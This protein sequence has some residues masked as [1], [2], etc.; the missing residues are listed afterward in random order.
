LELYFSEL[1]IRL[2]AK[3]N[4]LMS[5]DGDR[6]RRNTWVPIKEL[7]DFPELKQWSVDVEQAIEAIR[8]SAHLILSED[9][10]SV[11]RS[12]R[13]PPIEFISHTIFVYNF[14]ESIPS[15]EWFESAFSRF[16]RVYA[17]NLCKYRE[18]GLPKSKL[19]LDFALEES[20]QRAVNY[21][22]GLARKQIDAN[23]YETTPYSIDR[24]KL[25]EEEVQHYEAQSQ[26]FTFIDEKVKETLNSDGY[27]VELFKETEAELKK[28][29]LPEREEQWFN[30]LHVIFKS[31]FS[32]NHRESGF[33]AGMQKP[34]PFGR[35]RG[36]NRT[37]FENGEQQ[38][39]QQQQQSPRQHRSERATQRTSESD[40]A[41]KTK[42]SVDNLRQS[43]LPDSVVKVVLHESNHNTRI[44]EL[45]RLVRAEFENQEIERGSIVYL[46]MKG[47]NR[48]NPNIYIRCASAE[49]AKTVADSLGPVGEASVIT[50]DEHER[51]VNRAC[52][53]LAK[54]YDYNS[55]TQFNRPG[56]AFSRRP[57]RDNQRDNQGPRQPSYNNSHKAPH[58][59]H[60]TLPQSESEPEAPRQTELERPP[61]E[62][63][64]HNYEPG[65][66]VKIEF[67]ADASSGSLQTIGNAFKSQIRQLPYQ[68]GIVYAGIDFGDR[69]SSDEAEAGEKQQGFVRFDTAEN[70]ENFLEQPELKSVGEASILQGEEERQYIEQIMRIR[71]RKSYLRRARSTGRGGG[72]GSSSAVRRRSA[73]HS[74]DS[75]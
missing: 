15:Q 3:M 71:Q 49:V 8:K 22:R 40:F 41:P 25:C 6:V 26:L 27:D 54:K 38:P 30:N 9:G 61:R 45:K 5:G 33:F 50:G 37:K 69:R 24:E 55:G 43:F 10:E 46:D 19:F 23:Q 32:K 2:D 68:T 36:A 66:I 7:I 65:C 44:G 14:P 4:K 28:N 29:P 74:V 20:A 51:Y 48:S 47:D 64:V 35:Q 57:Q 63:R 73:R 75:D 12:H 16:G 1:Y 60:N 67:N 70:A 42:H 59:H 52:R 62:P 11:Q 17:S 56:R 58:H 53:I 31:D 21:F 18:S 34:R 72:R 13:P 39:A